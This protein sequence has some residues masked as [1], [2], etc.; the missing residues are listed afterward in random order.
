MHALTYERRRLTGVR[1]SWLIPVA[2][3]AADAVVAELTLRQPGLADPIR[4]LTAGVPLLPLP[5]AALGAGAVGA[6]SAGHEFRYP[7]PGGILRPLR[8]RFGLL[9]AKLLVVGVFAALLGAASLAVDGLLLRLGDHAAAAPI[10]A[11]ARHGHVPAALVGYLALTVAGGW[12]GLLGGVLLRSAAAGMLLLIT[13]PILTEPV[14]GALAERGALA[15]G[16]LRALHWRALFPVDRGHDWLYGTFSGL[17]SG[18]ALSTAELAVAVVVPIL[19]LLGAYVL[20]LPRRSA[21]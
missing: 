6:L 21:L 7:A 12:I 18:T 20:L 13:V 1:S 8:R 17:R 4:V 9:L 3:L 2:V 14:A 10:E 19:L 11:A 15:S 5:L 16:G